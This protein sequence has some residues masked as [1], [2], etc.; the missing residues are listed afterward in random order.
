MWR[1]LTFFSLT[2]ELGCVIFGPRAKQTRTNTTQ[3]THYMRVKIIEAPVMQTMTSQSQNTQ[4]VQALG[5]GGCRMR[6]RWAS[7]WLTLTFRWFFRLEESEDNYTGAI[8]IFSPAWWCLRC[9]CVRRY[10]VV[11]WITCCGTAG[12]C[13]YFSVIS[14]SPR[15]AEKM[16]IVFCKRAAKKFP[17]SLSLPQTEA[18]CNISL[19]PKLSL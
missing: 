7:A 13:L 10:T 17:T 3:H 5:F 6:P 12:T 18:Q 2:V 19:R 9:N 16:G 15:A 1:S 8:C 4:D 11:C 14:P